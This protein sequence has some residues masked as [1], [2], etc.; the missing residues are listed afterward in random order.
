[1]SKLNNL[2]IMKEKQAVTTSLQI[3][4][5]FEKEHR[6]VLKAVDDLKE[7]LAQKYADQVLH[8]E[9]CDDF[10]AARNTG[11]DAAKGLW[12]MWI[13]S[14]ELIENPDSMIDFFNS[15]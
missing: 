5:V 9:W 1:M 14:D 7:G 2:V 8:F 15:G 11:I 3:A 12:F 13:D 4:D 10:S 6:V